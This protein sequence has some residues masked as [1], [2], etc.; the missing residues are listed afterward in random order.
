[1]VH[2]TKYTVVGG[3]LSLARKHVLILH[4][5]DITGELVGGGLEEVLSSVGGVTCLEMLVRTLRSIMSIQWNLSI[6]VTVLA[7]HLHT[8]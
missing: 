4:S 2:V 1:M 3:G 7:G 5:Y 8:L 6:M